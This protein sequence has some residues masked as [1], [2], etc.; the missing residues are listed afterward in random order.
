MIK[1]SPFSLTPIIF[2]KYKH[3]TLN[4]SGSK[5]FT[6]HQYC[7]SFMRSARLLTREQFSNGLVLSPR[8]ADEEQPGGQELVMTGQELGDGPGGARGGPLLPLA[9]LAAFVDGV[10]QQEQGLLRGL[11]A[12]ER[13]EDTSEDRRKKEGNVIMFSSV[14]VT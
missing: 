7:N 1:V 3:E 13:Q 2:K 4:Y 12:Q 14:C 11:N 6:D 10:H 8:G 9:E 5:L